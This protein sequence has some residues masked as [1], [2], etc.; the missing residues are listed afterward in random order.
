MYASLTLD[1][2]TFAMD[3]ALHVDAFWCVRVSTFS[4]KVC[5]NESCLN[6]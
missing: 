4:E 5:A 1:A 3:T 2:V 6:A